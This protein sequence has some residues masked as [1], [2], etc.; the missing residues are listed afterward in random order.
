[1]RPAHLLPERI[2]WGRFRAC[3]G[4]SMALAHRL[5]ARCSRQT[6]DDRGPARKLDPIAVRIEDHRYPRHVSK[7]YRSKALAHALA[8]QLGMH[9]IDIGDL[10]RDVAPSARLT[11]RIDGCGAVFLEKKQ[12]VSQAKGRTVRAG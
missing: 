11:N 6:A 3:V 12:A 1:M 2:G 7:R 4:T 10:Q 8:S 5:T 9:G